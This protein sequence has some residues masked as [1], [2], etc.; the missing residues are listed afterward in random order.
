LLPTAH[1]S[2]KKQ[3]ER[4]RKIEKTKRKKDIEEKK[5]KKGWWW[6]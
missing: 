5:N 2:R 6:C 3:L 1:E 4:E